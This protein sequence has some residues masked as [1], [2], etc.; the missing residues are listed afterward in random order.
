MFVTAAAAT[1]NE[2]LPVV[3]GTSIGNPDNHLE[4][5]SSGSD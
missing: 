2:C 4:N 1:E 5:D 3:S